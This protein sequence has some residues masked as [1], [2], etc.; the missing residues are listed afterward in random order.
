MEAPRVEGGGIRVFSGIH[1]DV[2][3]RDTEVSADGKTCSVSE[4]DGLNRFAVGGY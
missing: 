1:A 2:P 3:S 4:G